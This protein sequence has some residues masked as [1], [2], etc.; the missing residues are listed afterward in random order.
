MS[1]AVRDAPSEPR[2][3]VTRD[4]ALRAAVALADEAGLESLTMRSLAQELG[5]VPMALYKHV[6]NKDDLIDG[7]VDIIIGEIDPAI[8]GADWRSAVRERILSARRALLRHP[9]ARA[10]IESRTTMTPVVLGYMESM[11]GLF[12][13]GGFSV[14][15]TH[16]ALHALAGRIWGF[17]QEVFTAPPPSQGATV[18]PDAQAAASNEMATRYPYS[19]ELA[20][21]IAHDQTSVVGG[22]CDDQFEFEFALDSL[23]DG[24]ERLHRQGWT[25]AEHHRG[26]ACSRGCR[27]HT[28]VDAQHWP[29][30]PG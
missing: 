17:T 27:A 24:F 16:H 23:L 30:G 25:S 26:T 15:L 8:A 19:H 12:R 7:M 4:R 18:D 11:I 13:T 5:V 9:W 1:Q 22:G 10:A 6:A 3:R 14:D 28:G 29:G 20:M 21:A 2:A